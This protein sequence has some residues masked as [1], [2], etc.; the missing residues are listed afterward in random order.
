[1]TSRAATACAA[2]C[3]HVPPPYRHVP[4]CRAATRAAVPPPTYKGGAHGTWLA[5]REMQELRQRGDN[6]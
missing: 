3:R 6:G 2:T 4:P 1:M 5:T